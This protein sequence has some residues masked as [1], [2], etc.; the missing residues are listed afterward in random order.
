[1]ANVVRRGHFATFEL[2]TRTFSGDP[3]GRSSGIAESVSGASR[4]IARAI[5]SGVPAAIGVVCLH[6]N[7]GS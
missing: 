1:M 5:K 7:G 4:P 6:P 2:L 3:G